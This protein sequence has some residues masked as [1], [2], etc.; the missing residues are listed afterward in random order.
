MTEPANDR[1]PPLLAPLLVAAGLVVAVLAWMLPVNVRSLSPVLLHAAG[2]GT[3]SLATFGRQL[4]DVEKIGPASLVLAAARTVHN[5]QA[6]AL[7]TALDQLIARQPALATWGGWDPFLDPIFH[8]REAT[9]A[10][11]STPVET[12]FLPERSRAALHATLDQ[13]GSEGV[14]DLLRLR[15]LTAT[16]RFVPATR[17]GGQPLDSLLLL[18]AALYQGE[19]MSRSLQV[20]LR[21]LAEAAAAKKELGELEPF[22]LDLL[23]LGRRLDWIQLGEL[24][25]RTDSTKTVDEYA[26]L[27][28]VAPDQLPLI[29]SAAL[30][31][32][33]ADRVASYLIQFGKAGAD[34]LRLALGDGQGAVRQLLLR[35]VPINRHAGPALS[36]AGTLVLVHPRVMLALKYLGYL[37]GIFLVLRGLDSWVVTPGLA[38]PATGPV[39][40]IRAGL[41]SLLLASLLV[42]VTEPF[43]LKGA[44][45]SEYGVQ[46]RLPILLASPAAPPALSS[47]TTMDTSTLISIGLF[48]VLQV[49]IYL[50]CLRKVREIDAQDI[51]PLLKLRLMEN[52]ENLFDSGLY[53]GMIGT[54]AALVLQVL[55]LIQPN[56]L[57]AYS[58]N[59]FGIV[60]VALVKIRHIR[61]YKR[62]LIIQVQ[63]APVTP[64]TVAS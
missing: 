50:I 18:A 57:A 17:P 7:A 6:P 53:V 49:V 60:C 21:E 22:F 1:K 59:L 4:V 58:S 37:A 61:T 34:D 39:L 52:E 46:L 12:F 26:H 48:A 27:A 14:Q 10:A 31:T 19:D 3:P 33:S 23:A 25:R 29:Y 41:L 9:G 2:E 43:L 45:S 64:A 30:F 47:H 40:P 38:G 63:A 35:Q 16:G 11:A 36:A 24:L 13:S 54:A 8:L 56:L 42:V 32:D 55:G 44:P 62:S 51:S 5:P 15:D 28:R 20:Q